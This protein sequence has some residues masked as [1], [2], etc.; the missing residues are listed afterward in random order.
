MKEVG[1]RIKAP[2]WILIYYAAG[3]VGIGLVVWLLA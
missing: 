1:R 2:R 3:Y